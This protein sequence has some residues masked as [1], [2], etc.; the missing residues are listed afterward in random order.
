MYSIIFY[1]IIHVSGEHFY[2]YVDFPRNSTLCNSILLDS[3]IFC[4]CCFGFL[5]FLGFFFFFVFFLGGV[6]GF[7]FSI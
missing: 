1:C 7:F 6:L 2:I 5:V 3:I 4:C